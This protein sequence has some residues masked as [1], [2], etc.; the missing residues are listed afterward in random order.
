MFFSEGYWREPHTRIRRYTIRLDGFVSLRAPFKG[1]EVLTKLFVFQGNRLHVNYATSAAGRVRIELQDARGQ[2]LE[3]FRLEDCTEMIGDS[4]AHTVRWANRTNL[5]AW[6][7]KPVRMR[8]QMKDADLYSFRFLE[9][10]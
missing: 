4:V 5:D 6:A 1:G 2:P 8:I 10:P 9:T 3:G 7:G